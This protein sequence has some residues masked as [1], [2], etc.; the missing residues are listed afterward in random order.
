MPSRR[1]Q[2]RERLVAEA[3]RDLELANEVI[4]GKWKI[5]ILARLAKA[6]LRFGALRRALGTVS[7]KVLTQQLR[8]LEADQMVTRTVLATVPPHVTYALSP[9]GRSLCTVVEA[10]AR[11]GFEHRRHLASLAGGDVE[12]RT[13]QT[14]RRALSV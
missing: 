2:R 4:S 7:E 5:P 12:V 1:Y 8:E 6:P 14:Q 3:T 10:L 13:S 11:W 9:H